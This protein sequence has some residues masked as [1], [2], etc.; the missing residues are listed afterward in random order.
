[1][2]SKHVNKVALQLTSRLKASEGAKGIDLD[3]DL[4]P[5][6]KN[7]P[8]VRTFASYQSY[9]AKWSEPWEAQAL[10]RARPV[11]GDSALTEEFTALIDPLRYP[12]QM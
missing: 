1:K 3:A 2:L 6:G 12:E 8:L 11:A 10:L 7:G 9:Y 5:E 4:R